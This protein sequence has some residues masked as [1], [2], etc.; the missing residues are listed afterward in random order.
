[1][2]KVKLDNG[3][4]CWAFGSSQYVQAAVKNVE[5]HLQKKGLALPSGWKCKNVLPA[6]YRPEIDISEECDATD[7]SY[8]QSLIGILRWMVE[9]GRV[10][11]NV[12]V[13]MMS[14]HLAMP[15]QGHLEA[16]YH[17][18][19]YLKAHHNGEMPFDPSYPEIDTSQFVRQDWSK[20]VYG[21]KIPLVL[22]G[23]LRF[24]IGRLV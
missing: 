13:S 5:A 9:L 16:L 15:G 7:A 4:E 24:V 2:R 22:L 17:I 18:F 11:M 1:M 19:G 23:I 14:S 21:N 10:D 8:Y 12:E 6:N 20:T 3:N